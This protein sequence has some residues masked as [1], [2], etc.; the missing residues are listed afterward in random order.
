MD[1]DGEDAPADIPRL[2]DEL[3]SHGTARI[4]FAERTK[5]SEGWIF[6]LFYTIYRLLHRVLVGQR[7]RVGNFSVMNRRCLESLCTSSELWN[8]FAASAF[9]TRQPMSFVETSRAT[10]LAGNSKMNFPSLVTHG[11]SALS[12]FSDRVSTRLL[13]ASGVAACFTVLGMT[14][15]L[16][17]RLFTEY[18]I[19]GWATATLGVLLLLLVQIAMFMLTFS[20]LTLLTRGFSSFIPVRDYVPFLREVDEVWSATFS[21]GKET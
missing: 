12:V 18:A 16:I 1:G 5:R 20:F 8:H 19:P 11:L 9:A 3:D 17:V 13:I 4:V 6:S 21:A 7:I 2:L 15:V 14:A 10:R